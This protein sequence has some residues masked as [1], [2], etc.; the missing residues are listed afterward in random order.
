VA[1]E[2]GARRGVD[3]RAAL[4]SGDCYLENEKIEG[5]HGRKRRKALEEFDTYLTANRNLIPNW[6]ERWRNE[7]AMATGF[8]DRQ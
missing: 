3:G 1:W 7:E 8:V 6:G 4:L 5:D 2:H